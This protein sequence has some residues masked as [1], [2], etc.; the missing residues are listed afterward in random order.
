MA[1]FIEIVGLF[2][3]IIMAELITPVLLGNPPSA[4]GLVIGSGAY[5]LALKR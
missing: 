2:I 3:V 4:G 5:I 1:L